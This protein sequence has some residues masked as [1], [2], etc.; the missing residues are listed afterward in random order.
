[1]KQLKK[2]I[3]TDGGRFH[4][5][6]FYYEH[7]GKKFK[8]HYEATTNVPCASKGGDW[9]QSLCV[10]KPDGTWQQVTDA[11]MLG[12]VSHYE[13]DRHDRDLDYVG[14]KLNEAERIFKKHI[15]DIYS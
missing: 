9:Y 14:A 2:I 7:N 5:A 8:V 15:V 6:E 11:E 12:A 1:M 3:N 4:F 10:M 13:L